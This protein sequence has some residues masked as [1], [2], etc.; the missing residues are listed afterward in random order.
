MSPSSSS[1][2]SS[3][4]RILLW[5]RAQSIEPGIQWAETIMRRIDKD[6]LTEGISHLG[7]LNANGDVASIKCTVKLRQPGFFSPS[8]GSAGKHSWL[9]SDRRCVHDD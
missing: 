4:A 3:S 9:S 7:G 6:S 2:R 5:T 1:C 8:A